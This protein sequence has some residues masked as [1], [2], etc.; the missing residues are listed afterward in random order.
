MQ[1][2]CQAKLK[3][4]QQNKQDI[5]TALNDSNELL[6]KSDHPLKQSKMDPTEL[7]TMFESAHSLQ[8]NLETNQS[9]NS[10]GNVQRFSIK[11]WKI[12]TTFDSNV[13]GKIVKQKIEL[14]FLEN[15]NKKLERTKI[16]LCFWW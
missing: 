14:Y 3:S 15:I 9:W 11:V 1:N 7:T 6:S 8:T 16:M 10:K 2:E 12:K 5:E 13:I 4:I